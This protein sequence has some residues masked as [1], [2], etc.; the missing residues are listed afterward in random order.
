[1]N[2]PNE[3]FSN[4]CTAVYWLKPFIL[5]VKLVSQKWVRLPV[6]YGLSK[7]HHIRVVLGAWVGLSGI[8][9]H[10]TIK[11][12][13]ALFMLLCLVQKDWE[14]VLK[15]QKDVKR[16][17]EK[18]VSRERVLSIW[19][20]QPVSWW[21]ASFCFPPLCWQSITCPSVGEKGRV[22]LF[23]W[24]IESITDGAVCHSQ[25]SDDHSLQ[26]YSIRIHTRSRTDG[27]NVE[28][29]REIKKGGK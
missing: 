18:G 6:I 1:M 12:W 20:S 25:E 13:Q 9:K 4:V 5:C 2:C 29:Q 15:R 16:Y 14:R 27:E 21:G 19:I 26:H 8:W 17:E 11:M 28:R 24:F 3:L 23:G 10:Q 7:S 22:P